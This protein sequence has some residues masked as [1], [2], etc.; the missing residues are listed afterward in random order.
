MKNELSNIYA[1]QVLVTEAKKAK[2]NKVKGPKT[3]SLEG[4]D[5]AKPSQ[6]ADEK[7]KKNLKKP[8]EKKEFS[9]V[10]GKPSKMK[11]SQI[12]SAFNKIFQSVLKEDFDFQNET[13]ETDKEVEDET[14]GTEFGDETPENPETEEGGEEP[15]EGEEED[16]T[17]KLQDIVSMLQDI[18]SKLSGAEE[19][20]AEEGEPESDVEGVEGEEGKSEEAVEEVAPEG[21]EEENPYEESLDLKGQLS[22][23]SGKL[24]EYLTKKSNNKVKGT[25]GKAKKGGKAEEGKIPEQEGKPK[26][27]NPS[28]KAYQN[29]KGSNTVSNIKKGDNL[30]K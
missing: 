2:D 22:E 17:V 3:G 13:P 11:E 24:G 16:L 29:P 15:I 7:A 12:P 18:V 4:A 1:N 9:E 20:E 27:F 30:F 19:E 26:A 21:V 8:E 25:L 10:K 28:L 14:F 23:L 6:G 5:K